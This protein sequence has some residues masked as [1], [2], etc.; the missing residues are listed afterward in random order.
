M[1]DLDTSLLRLHVPAVTSSSIT[2]L[3]L[4]HVKRI[5]L[6]K[7]C[8]KFAYRPYWYTTS[9]VNTNSRYFRNVTDTYH[10][11]YNA[12]QVSSGLDIRYSIPNFF[13]APLPKHNLDFWLSPSE[14]RRVLHFFV[15]DS[16]RFYARTTS[17]TL[18]I[19]SNYEKFL[20]FRFL[21]PPT[22]WLRQ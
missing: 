22:K 20:V 4:V 8:K 15:R 14:Q 3:Q 6:H 5:N 21:A 2:E 7:F 17:C 9:Y 11:F 18:E 16:R 13:Y 12:C 10:H 19:S 1:F